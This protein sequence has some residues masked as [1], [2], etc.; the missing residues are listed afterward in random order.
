MY[1][2][3]FMRLEVGMNSLK[4]LEKIQYPNKTQ[5]FNSTI[6]QGRNII[7]FMWKILN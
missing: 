4:D 1:I 3:W 7:W 2:F 6:C 5:N